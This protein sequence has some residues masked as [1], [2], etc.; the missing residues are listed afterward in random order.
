MRLPWGLGFW[1]SKAKDKPPLLPTFCCVIPF[2]RQQNKMTSCLN[3]GMGKCNRKYQ[4]KG[5]I[6]YLPHLKCNTHMYLMFTSCSRDSSYLVRTK[7]R[8]RDSQKGTRAHT[9]LGEKFQVLQGMWWEGIREIFIFSQR[10]HTIIYKFENI[11]GEWEL[12][13]GQKEGKLFH[14]NWRKGNGMCVRSMARCTEV[15]FTW[16]LFLRSW[17]QGH[18][19]RVKE[20]R[21]SWNEFCLREGKKR[22]KERGEESFEIAPWR[23]RESPSQGHM[24][25]LPAAWEPHREKHHSLRVWGFLQ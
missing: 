19:M 9:L 18:L 5:L 12:F 23:A 4:D 1:N 7:R 16:H 8:E 10:G 2:L 11:A 3:V 24:E 25:G 20:E 15:P 22:E 14:L 13:K 21:L 17:R 6:Y